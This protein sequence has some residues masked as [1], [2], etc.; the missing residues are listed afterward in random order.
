MFHRLRKTKSSQ[1]PKIDEIQETQQGD[2]KAQWLSD[3]MALDESDAD[4]PD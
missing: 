3:T 4:L 1:P 2:F